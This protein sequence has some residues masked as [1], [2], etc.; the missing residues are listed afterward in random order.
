MLVSKNN[1]HVILSSDEVIFELTIIH[2]NAMRTMAKNKS[3]LFDLNCS[4]A[5]SG[6]LH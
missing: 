5:T 1:E 4:F 2:S 6:N 3:K